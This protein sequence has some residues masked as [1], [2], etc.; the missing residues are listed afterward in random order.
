MSKALLEMLSAR[1]PEGIRETYSFRGD[2]VA[3]IDPAKVV[4]ICNFLKYD[5]T[6]DMKLLLSVTAVDYLGETS[7]FEV[8]TH[9]TSLTHHHR[10]RLRMRAPSNEAPVVPSIANIWRGANWWERQVYDL[11]GI[12]FEGHPDLRRLY[13]P[14]DWKGHPL[15]KDYPTKLRQPIIPERGIQ[16]LIRGPGPHPGTARLPVIKN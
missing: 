7:R 6:T 12:K 4:E 8:V 15:R 2:D 10:L 9:M 13:M 3:V 5:P 1:F 14:E 16:D 11:Y